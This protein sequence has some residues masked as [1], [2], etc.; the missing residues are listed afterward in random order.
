MTAL[1]TSIF[2]AAALADARAKTQRRHDWEE[3]IAAV[4]AET[5]ELVDEE[6]RIIESLQAHKDDGRLDRLLRE[7]GLGNVTNFAPLI[8]RRP[9]PSQ[10]TRSL[11]TERRLHNAAAATVPVTQ[12]IEDDAIAGL[13]EEEDADL[14]TAINEQPPSWAL[15]S[16]LRTK[17][18]QK[19]ALQQFAIRLLLRPTIAQR[20]SGLPRNY[21]TDRDAPRI[22]VERLLEKLN[23]LRVQMVDIQTKEDSKYKDLIHEESEMDAQEARAKSRSLD[24]ELNQDL[25]S[26]MSKRMSMEE[27]IL[28]VSSNMLNSVNPDR[29]SAFR[30]MLI[31][32][33]KSRQND[34]NDLLLRTLIPN[35]F[36]MSTSLIITIL[37]FFRKSKNLKDFDMFL[38]MLTGDGYEVNLGPIGHF[39]RRT[40]NGVNIVVPPLDSN[41][42]LIYTELIQCAMRFNQPD[43]ADAWL[44]AARTI[45][46]FDNFQTL[47][48]YIRFYSIRQD[49]EKGVST[50]RRAVT[51]LVSTTNLE[52]GL[53][54][55]LIVLMAHLCDACNK[56]N[57]SEALISAAMQSG[58]DPILPSEQKDIVP[59][60]DPSFQRWIN[61]AQTAPIENVDRPLWQKCS[62]FAHAFGTQ[63]SNIEL[64]EN[65]SK[66]R[67][68]VN[69]AARHAQS[70]MSNAL[71]EDS[72]RSRN[73]TSNTNSSSSPNSR[74]PT[75]DSSEVSALKEEVAQLRELVFEIRKQHIEASFKPHP[76]QDFAF[77]AEEPAPQPAKSQAPSQQSHQAMNVEFERASQ[78]TTKS[79]SGRR[80]SVSTKQ[81][82][83]T[84]STSR[85]S[86]VL[87][88]TQMAQSASSQAN[89]ENP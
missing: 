69:F 84:G 75:N 89:M 14:Q 61:A 38:Q 88:Q 6:Q 85:I 1:Y 37:A 54:K 62:D 78:K 3:K 26:F 87:N 55:R 19:L 72:S 83:K 76:P 18:I 20:Y 22:N 47:F 40:F 32:F 48:T 23:T 17:A 27:L 21:P 25:Q 12:L 30:S 39:D 64:S 59:I 63:L 29:T 68:F 49:W 77:P 73:P 24:A 9:V 45:G 2:A 53:A 56:K 79:K 81:A 33:T 71:A 34:L 31:T 35:K 66:T 5:S 86:R 16:P 36:Y 82:E 11:H 58:F 65:D 60:T 52:S 10:P 50:L 51:Y 43:R 41:S 15:G 74:P 67:Q 42:M 57:V 8:Q 13:C 28:R 44:Q 46:F 80:A 7:R 70:A 4:K